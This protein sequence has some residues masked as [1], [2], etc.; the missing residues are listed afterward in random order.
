[1]IEILKTGRI[2]IEGKRTNFERKILNSGSF[3]PALVRWAGLVVIALVE[4]TWLAI[5][6]TLPLTGFLSYFRGSIT[7]FITSLAFVTI[8][9]WTASRGK[10]VQ[11]PVFHDFSHNPWLMILAHVGAFG[12][13]F[14]LTIFVAEGDVASSPLYVFWVF[15]WAATG[16]CAGFFWMLAAMPAKVW[17][18][19]IRQNASLVCAGFI[20]IAASWILA[21]L[22]NRAW[23]PLI[24]PTFLAV[25]WMLLA[26]GQEVVSQPADLVLGTSQ[27]SVEISSYCAGYEG[28]GL[29]SVFVG[30]Y[31]WFFRGSLRFPQAFIL[32]PCG[33]LVIWLVNVVRITLLVMIGAYVSPKIAVD[34]FHSSF[35]WIGFIVVALG[36]V[37]LTQRFQFFTVRRS[38]VETEDRNGNPTA[39]YLAPLTAL[40]VIIL[41]ARAF[42]M[43]FDWFYPVRVL[44]TAVVIWLFWKRKMTRLDLAGI[45]SG[46][47]IAIGVAVFIVW[48]GLER[49]LGNT[50]T[51][52]VIPGSLAEM[53]AG[54]AATWLIFRVLGT[55]VTVP[56]AEELAFRGYILRRL[57]S[58]DF[59]KITPRFTWPSFLLSSIMFGALHGQWLAGTIAG[60]FYAWAIYRR[61]RLRDAIMAHATTNALISADVILCGNWSLWS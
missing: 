9:V 21:F 53:P 1:V 39:A 18:R 10:L 38:E 28:I 16:L 22:T 35:G 33:I 13:F 27:F 32:L 5:G 44:G 57:I 34:G 4:L 51:G 23:A 58:S 50:D 48:I 25:E 56:I 6:F 11:L 15:T 7:V 12:S 54:L 59:D 43:G 36:M 40:L 24:R 3:N 2:A 8:L 19:L 20:I 61:G 26:L 14:W 45:W 46:R 41:V 47:A 17:L 30:G 31:L 49:V 52:S 60:M 42:S 29:I 55:V 37:A